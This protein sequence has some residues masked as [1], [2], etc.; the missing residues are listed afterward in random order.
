M[1]LK[2]KDISTIIL[3][4][5]SGDRLGGRGKAFLEVAGE[6]YIERAVKFF[7]K[8]SEQIVVTLEAAELANLQTK[9]TLLPCKFIPGGETRQKSFAIALN[10]VAGETVL[11]HDVA[12]PLMTLDITQRV[13]YF[14]E[15]HVAVAP[16]VSVKNRDLL[17]YTVDGFFEAPVS[18]ENLVTVQTPQAYRRDILLKTMAATLQQ[19]WEEKGI[20]PLVKRAGFAVKTIEGDRENLKVTY[21]EDIAIAEKI[22]K[23]RETI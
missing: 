1:A 6:T 14:A 15:D 18:L 11:I 17:S 23:S 9:F 21:P 22:I 10:Y 5:G 19:G 12:R 2:N 13:L 3:A 16:V 7:A 20:V 4:A 8:F